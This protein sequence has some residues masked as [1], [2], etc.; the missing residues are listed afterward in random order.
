MSKEIVI[1]A[2]CGVGMGSSQFLKMQMDDILKKNG[3]TG[4]RTLCGDLMTCTATDCDVIFTQPQLA[5]TLVN[6]AKVPVIA[7]A[8]YTNKQVVGEALMNYL[9]SL[10]K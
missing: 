9:N 4:V 5:E 6:K 10:E 1:L 7:L 3:I 8:N 2:V